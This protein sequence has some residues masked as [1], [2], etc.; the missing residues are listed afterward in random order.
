[1]RIVYLAS[2]APEIE[3]PTLT[4]ILFGCPT[5]GFVA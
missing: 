5:K 2:G 4:L 1:M 3:L